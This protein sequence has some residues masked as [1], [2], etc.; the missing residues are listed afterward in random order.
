MLAR[1]AEAAT[2]IRQRLSAKPPNPRARFVNFSLSNTGL[3]V[4]RS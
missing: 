1:D 2:R 3:Q 4:T